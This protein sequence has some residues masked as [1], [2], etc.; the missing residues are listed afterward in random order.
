[1]QILAESSSIVQDWVVDRK[2]KGYMK[3]PRLVCETEGKEILEANCA[4]VL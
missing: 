3:P 1:L 2:K 4:S